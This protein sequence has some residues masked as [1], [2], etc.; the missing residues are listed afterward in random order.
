M[1]SVGFVRAAV[2]PFD[3]VSPGAAFVSTRTSVWKAAD[4]T[5]DVSF[6]VF[7]IAG[8]SAHS[9][10]GLFLSFVGEIEGGKSLF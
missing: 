3:R 4:A 6:W 7:L 8:L 9:G 1:T 5:D 2:M 10:V